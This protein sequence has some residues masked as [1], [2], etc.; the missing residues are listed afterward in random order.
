MT[1]KHHPDI[2]TLGSF[3]FGALD[4]ARA[5][6]VAA[7]VAGCPKC[8][9]L[10][11]GFE[12][13]GG[14]LLDQAD[15]APMTMAAGDKMLDV[16]LHGADSARRPVNAP[17]ADVDLATVL[18]TFDEG[19]WTWMGPGV[20]YKP[21]TTAPPGEARLFLLKAAPGTSLPE[22]THT[23]T[24]LTL[25]LRGA[26]SHS[27]GRFAAGDLEEADDTVEHQPIV[28]EGDTCICL[29]AM[30]GQ[31]KLKGLMG[32]LMQPFVRL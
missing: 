7:H 11:R 18:S 6:V 3:A 14:V 1:A 30:D 4:K 2:A 24:E 16:I 27:G 20:Y 32:R 12:E 31:L 5:F 13:T 22:H 10:V 29:V 8:K 19:P 17:L 15:P 26:F 21:L 28:D 25:I 23:G 9:A